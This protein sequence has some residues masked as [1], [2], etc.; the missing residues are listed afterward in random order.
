MRQL[1]A[2]LVVTASHRSPR[3]RT[4]MLTIGGHNPPDITPWVRS[5]LS[6]ARPDET[7]GIRIRI[8]TQCTMSFSVTGKGVLKA[9]L[10]FKS[11]MYD[12]VGFIRPC[13]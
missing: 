6:V 5:P 4:L 12:S 3:G 10:A 11:A 8:R 7:P 9:K 1:M 2:I 13:H